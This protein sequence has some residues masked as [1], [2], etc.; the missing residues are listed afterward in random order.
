M[1]FDFYEWL[2]YSGQNL[3]MRNFR[4]GYVWGVLI[5]LVL[6]VVIKIFHYYLFC[7]QKRVHEMRIPA[8]G[9]ALFVA[10][11]ALVDLVKIV[12]ADFD[13][14][15]V[16]KVSILETK[17]GITMNINVKYDIYGKQYPELAQDLKKTIQ[18]NLNGRL[19]IDNIRYIEVHCKKTTGNQSSKF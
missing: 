18:D 7:R 11:G 2:I 4:V 9:G 5:V 12:A 13:Y 14:V 8:E 10:S 3:N 17:I 19:G 6:L 16:L 15:E 1:I